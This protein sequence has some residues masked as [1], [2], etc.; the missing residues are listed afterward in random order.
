MN[1][2]DFECPECGAKPGER[3]RTLTGKMNPVSH[4]KRKRAALDRELAEMDT[5]E[6]SEQ[7]ER[8]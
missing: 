5:A 7:S 6:A 2:T 4:A 3:C 1:A 8:D